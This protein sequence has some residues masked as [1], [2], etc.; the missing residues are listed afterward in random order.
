MTDRDEHD[1]GKNRGQGLA[2]VNDNQRR[3]LLDRG[4]DRRTQ[5]QRSVRSSSEDDGRA[6]DDPSRAPESGTP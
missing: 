5:D 1:T 2:G 4:G 6:K 3:D